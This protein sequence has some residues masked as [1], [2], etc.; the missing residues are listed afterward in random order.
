MNTV[1]SSPQGNLALGKANLKTKR[2]IKVI[3]RYR[4]S[5]N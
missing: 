5:V 4:K 1:P 3:L 2:K